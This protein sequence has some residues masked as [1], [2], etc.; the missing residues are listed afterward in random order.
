MHVTQN[1]HYYICA[2]SVDFHLGMKLWTYHKLIS[3][4]QWKQTLYHPQSILRLWNRLPPLPPISMLKGY[5]L[6][7]RYITW[8]Q[9][10]CQ[11]LMYDIWIKQ[12]LMYSALKW[13]RGVC[14]NYFVDDCR[15]TTAIVNMH[16]EVSHSILTLS[17]LSSDT[18][19]PKQTSF[20]ICI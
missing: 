4:Q 14:L 13:E 16:F 19:A 10:C 1:V 15:W 2:R 18:I 11:N 8:H 7:K 5:C 12:Y 9:N 6:S 17:V 20:G 3:L